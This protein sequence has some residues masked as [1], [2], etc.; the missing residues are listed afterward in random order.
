MHRNDGG[1]GFYVDRNNLCADKFL[2]MTWILSI[3]DGAHNLL[4]ASV[5]D[6]E[7]VAKLKQWA[8]ELGLRVEVKEQ[9]AGKVVNK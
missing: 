5:V 8:Q 1:N 4:T 3:W 7:L 6:P 9:P 2:S